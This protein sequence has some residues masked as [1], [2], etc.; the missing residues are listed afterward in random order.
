[1]R[2]VGPCGRHGGEALITL[3]GRFFWKMACKAGPRRGGGGVDVGGGPLWP[4]VAGACL[5]AQGKPYP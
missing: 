3:T 4:P 5:F 2:G 1:M